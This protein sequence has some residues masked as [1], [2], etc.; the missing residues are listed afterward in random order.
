MRGTL[1]LFG[2]GERH[3][4]SESRALS[5]MVLGNNVSAVRLH[6]APGDRQTNPHAVSFGRQ[7]GLE[8]L[9]R[10]FERDARSGVLD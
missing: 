1:R 3:G 7:K 10:R 6:D 9:R 5:W 4:K 2:S 8:D